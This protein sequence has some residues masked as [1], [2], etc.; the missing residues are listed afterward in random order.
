MAKIDLT[1]NDVTAPGADVTSFPTIYLFKSGAKNKPILYTGSR[2]LMAF[3][4]FIESNTE[5][6][7]FI[8]SEL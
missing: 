4:A 5:P 8:R 1:A 2:E 7:N 3:V 6:S